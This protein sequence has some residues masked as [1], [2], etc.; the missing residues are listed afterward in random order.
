MDKLYMSAA[1]HIHTSESTSSIMRDVL[2]ALL[3]AFLCGV[4]FF[5]LYSAAVVLTAIAACV[6]FEH[7]FCVATKKA[8]TIKDLSA[9]V[10]GLLLG[11]NMP[12]AIPLWMVIIG[13]AFAIFIAKCLYGGL[14]KNFMNPALAGRCFML[15]AWTGAMTTFNAPFDAVTSATPLSV[16]KGG[17]GVLPPLQHMFLGITGGC[18][19]E[20]ST[21][22][23][24]IGF[25][26]L[27]YR[28]V[29]RPDTTLSLLISFVILTF[30]FGK[31]NSGESQFIYTLMQV[32]SGGLILGACFMA[33][34]YVT[35]PTT[36]KGHIIFGIGCG[37][38]TFLIRQFGGYPEGVSY[39]ILLMNV[40][41]PMI[42]KYTIPKPFGYNKKEASK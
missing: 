16:F 1:P 29:I 37:I 20:T 4:V 32:C 18:I 23:L 34:D 22:A 41:S 27:L 21:L 33:T 10:T 31:N 35:T 8:S 3:P 6:L 2:I 12:P 36:F 24:L 28:K 19:G 17:E 7:L 40:A 13:S 15:L 11:L 25:L 9:V 26:Y 30:C 38:L 42:E 14:G 39:A 5:G